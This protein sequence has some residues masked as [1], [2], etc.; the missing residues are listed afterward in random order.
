MGEEWYTHTNDCLASQSISCDDMVE[1]VAG[2]K[3]FRIRE[4]V[5]EAFQ[6][7]HD[8][9]VPVIFISAG[10]GNVIEEVTRQCIAE[11]S[12]RLSDVWPNVK[13]LSNNMLWDQNGE[14]EDFST[15][16]IHMFNK[17][18]QDAPL[19]LRQMLKG[20]DIG[21]L[22]GDGLGDLTMAHG[23]ETTDVLKFGFLNDKIQER[24]PKYTAPGGFDKVILNDGTWE[25]VLS[26]VLHKL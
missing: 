19:D 7:L 23:V 5:K 18:L 3:K 8:K 2:C 17:S 1:A 20:R 26:D 16:L 24:L 11:T 14:F 22:C 13:I 6:I 12:G 15:P 4:G 25:A 10:V 21:I 9:G